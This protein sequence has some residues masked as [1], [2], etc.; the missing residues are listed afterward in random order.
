MQ[1]RFI[2]VL[3]VAAVLLPAAHGSAVAKA[4]GK[5]GK[6]A[7]VDMQAVI[8]NVAEGKRER[9]KLEKE[10]KDKEKELLKAKEELDKMNEEWKKQAPLLSESARMQKQQE[11]QEKFLKLREEEMNFQNEIKKKEQAATQKIAV[12]VSKM[13]NTI[14][15]ERGFE[16]VFESSSSGLI[17]LKDPVDL[18]KEITAAYED[19]SKK[20][21]KGNTAKK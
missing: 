10:I 16:A 3:V 1:S 9:E 14:A 13:V 4:D 6:Y 12:N 21:S 15:A 8:L 7:V 11:F 17:Y 5:T 19:Q 20:D 18:T 2:K